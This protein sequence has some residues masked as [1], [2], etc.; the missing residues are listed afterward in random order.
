[1]SFGCA[2]GTGIPAR[3]PRVSRYLE[4][5]FTCIGRPGCT[6]AQLWEEQ[7]SHVDHRGPAA[8]DQQRTITQDPSTPV[9]DRGHLSGIVSL[10]QA[11]AIDE[12]LTEFG[13]H[14]EASCLPECQ[15]LV[16]RLVAADNRRLARA[17]SGCER[18]ASGM[19]FPIVE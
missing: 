8:V 4:T 12:W 3:S 15:W 13:P 6:D 10:Y 18:R 11:W 2:T 19:A 14:A 1:V 7:S 5:D 16:D 9:E 17:Y